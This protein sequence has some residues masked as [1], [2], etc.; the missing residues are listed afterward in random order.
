MAHFIL[1]QNRTCTSIAPQS[2]SRV[3]V[4]VDWVVAL[5]RQFRS[6]QTKVV[7]PGLRF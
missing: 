2:L 7:S 4:C 3:Q 1:A 6:A 5:D